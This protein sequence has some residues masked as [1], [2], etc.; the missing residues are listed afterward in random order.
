MKN[1]LSYRALGVVLLTLICS[2]VTLSAQA[3]HFRFGHFS[4][5]HRPD[6]A[7][8]AVDFKLEVAYRR[9]FFGNPSIGQ[10]FRPGSFNFGDGTSAA[11][12]F[13]V[14]AFNAQEDWIVGRA[15]TQGLE[16]GVVRHIYKFPNNGTG[17]PWVANLY[18]NARIS[19]LQNSAN[20]YYRVSTSIDLSEGNSSPVSS[21]APIVTCPR[22]ACRFLVPAIDKNGDALK[23]R[24]A[25]KSESAI[26]RLP[27]GLTIDSRSGLIDWSDST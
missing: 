18:S 14:I 23:F 19:T 20:S 2:L 11:F 5:E 15:I 1:I 10:T 8:N 13:E 22:G 16:P 12:D 7:P 21:L 9:S 27:S 4:W 3:T 26:T 24:L 25:A 17:K 6:V